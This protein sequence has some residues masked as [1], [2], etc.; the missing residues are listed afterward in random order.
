[1]TA[2]RETVALPDGRRASYELIG[3][4]EPAIY[5]QGGPGFSANLLRDDA[6]LL[7]ERFAVHLIDPPGS[8]ESS[9]PDDPSGYDHIGHARFYDEV[10]RALGVHAATIMGTSFGGT[11]ALTYA[12]LFPEATTR[13][14]AIA[15]RARGE[16]V[17]DDDAADETEQLIV[18]HSEASWFGEARVVWDSWTERVLATDDAAE[19]H[20]MM[21]TVLPLYTAHPDRPAVQSMIETWRN[22]ATI[23][24]E[25]IKV[26][27]S[28]LWQRIDIRPLL[29]DVRAPTLV[30]AAERDPLCGPAQAH[31]LGAAL[32]HATV[33]IIPDCGHFIGA[34][35]PVEFRRA[36]VAF[37]S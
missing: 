8:G 35:A 34:E 32:P 30:L 27:E 3:S 22:D 25:A 4:G 14:I 10:R 11:V 31:A 33:V 1:M 29:S 36:I 6:K 23:N 2:L 15:T 19:V 26:W 16:E 9:P 7:S 13:C 5:L 17:A 18:L 24:L 20:A 28:G 37:A 21:A 12:A